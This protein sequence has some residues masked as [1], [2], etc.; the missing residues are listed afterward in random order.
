MRG[1][2]D[3]ATT[4]V[5]CGV[6]TFTSVKMTL[7]SS[8]LKHFTCSSDFYTACKGLMCLLLHTNWFNVDG[9]V[10]VLII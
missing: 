3:F 8:A 10:L 4:L 7:T 9:S 1:R 6:A 5:A 2:H